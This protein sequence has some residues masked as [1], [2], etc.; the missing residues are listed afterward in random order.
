MDKSAH[1]FHL[2]AFLEHHVDFRHIRLDTRSLMVLVRVILSLGDIFFNSLA[3]A[4][5][6]DNTTRLS[7]Q[8]TTYTYEDRRKMYFKYEMGVAFNSVLK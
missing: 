7:L 2:G 4:P 3:I 5:E 8:Q 1:R 6:A